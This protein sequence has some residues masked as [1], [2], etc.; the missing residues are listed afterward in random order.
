MSDQ[1]FHSETA[2]SS[3]L[4]TTPPTLH[5]ITFQLLTIGIAVA[6]QSYYI[7]IVL[8]HTRHK[9]PRKNAAKIR[10]FLPSFPLSSS[11]KPWTGGGVFSR[12]EAALGGLREGPRPCRRRS[13]LCVM[14]RCFLRKF[15][16]RMRNFLDRLS[17][18]LDRVIIILYLN[19]TA[20]K[21]KNREVFMI[22]S[23]DHQENLLP[24]SNDPHF[25]F[26]RK[27][28]SKQT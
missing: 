14:L 20:K 17:R 11:G 3:P 12:P 28:F 6:S 1:L 23:H 15:L 7:Y 19:K 9:L 26:G 8:H 21:P 18:L 22:P 4:H 5:Y 2:G 16:D 24:S 25:Y 27:H 10:W 13:V